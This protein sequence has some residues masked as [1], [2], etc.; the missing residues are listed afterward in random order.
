MFLLQLLIFL[1]IDCSCFYIQLWQFQNF[2]RS[3]LKFIQVWTK[4]YTEFS[5]PCMFAMIFSINNTMM[6]TTRKYAQDLLTNM[7]HLSTPAEIFTKCVSFLFSLIP[8]P[9]W[10]GMCDLS[11]SLW[12]LRYESCVCVCVWEHACV[13]ACEHKFGV[14]TNHE[15]F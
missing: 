8:T 15:K 1:L 10:R 3:S 7:N 12:V 5:F 13:C 11:L 2:K 9:I 14:A 6:T 4:F